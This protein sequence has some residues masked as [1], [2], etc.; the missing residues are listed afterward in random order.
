MPVK[1]PKSFPETQ[2]TNM[3]YTLCV[4]VCVLGLQRFFCMFFSGSSTLSPRQTGG[5]WKS[6][7]STLQSIKH[8]YHLFTHTGDTFKPSSSRVGECDRIHTGIRCLVLSQG[9]GK[10]AQLRLKVSSCTVCLPLKPR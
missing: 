2:D 6:L 9:P 5:L 10:A 4:R 7:M 8:I 3:H 1:Q